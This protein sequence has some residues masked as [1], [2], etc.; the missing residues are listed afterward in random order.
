MLVNR[1]E[2]LRHNPCIL[3]GFH[4]MPHRK[5][6]HI[7]RAVNQNTLQTMLMFSGV[8]TGFHII[9]EKCCQGY[10]RC[11]KI[12]ATTVVMTIMTPPRKE[13]CSLFKYSNAHCW[14]DKLKTSFFFPFLNLCPRS[15]YEPI[16]IFKWISCK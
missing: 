14:N 4:A 6:L 8:P 7:T 3:T 2:K 13:T 12:C 16:C 5:N 9:L 10:Y 1:T 11:T 15:R